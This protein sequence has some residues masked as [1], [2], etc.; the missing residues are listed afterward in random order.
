MKEND[1]DDKGPSIP[2]RAVQSVE[3]VS[4]QI[5]PS[6]LFISQR[7]IIWPEEEESEEEPEDA[8][9]KK[10]KKDK[11]KLDIKM[12][13]KHEYAYPSIGRYQKKHE[14]ESTFHDPAANN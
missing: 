4:K 5:F 14:L 2:I 1:P 12:Y 9:K 10:K 3:R 6:Q 11:K 7:D 13:P 8:K